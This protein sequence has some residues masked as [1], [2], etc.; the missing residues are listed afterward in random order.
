MGEV[1]GALELLLDER[2]VLKDASSECNAQLLLWHRQLGGDGF[3][4][5]SQLFAGAAK[6][7][8]GDGVIVP[9]SFEHH[10]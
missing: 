10:W 4:N 7:L 5:C 6:Y 3:G 9:L 8:S 1:E 2:A